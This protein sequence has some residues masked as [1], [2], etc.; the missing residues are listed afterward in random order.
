MAR[1]PVGKAAEEGGH[2]RER[3]CDADG[4]SNGGE[5]RGLG[6]QDAGEAGVG[7]AAWTRVS[8]RNRTS[9]APLVAGQSPR[10]GRCRCRPA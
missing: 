7:P 10:P 3:N 1:T 9:S 2:R 8:R 5:D 6:E 4:G